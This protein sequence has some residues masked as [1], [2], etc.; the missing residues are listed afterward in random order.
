MGPPLKSSEK[1]LTHTFTHTPSVTSRT[2]ATF[3]HE[4]AD[5]PRD[6]AT[7]SKQATHTAH[8]S[9]GDYSHRQ[10]LAPSSWSAEPTRSSTCRSLSATQIRRTLSCEES[11][12]SCTARS[13]TAWKRGT[14]RRRARARVAES[15][16]N[17]ATPRRTHFKSPRTQDPACRPP[18]FYV[19]HSLFSAKK[20]PTGI[21][22]AP[23]DKLIDRS[24]LRSTHTRCSRLRLNTTLLLRKP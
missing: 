10:R 24:S 19:E 20:V 8:R 12:T 3:D 18:R 21:R 1:G 14:D 9:S 22:Q 13:T 2:D 15:D 7:P 5:G 11:S 16:T 17:T 23:S 6:S 4:V